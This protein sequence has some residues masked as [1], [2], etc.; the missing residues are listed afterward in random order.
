METDAFVV[1]NG[2][3]QIDS[4]IIGEINEIKENEEIRE[5]IN[6]L[7]SDDFVIHYSSKDLSIAE[8]SGGS[9]RAKIKGD[10]SLDSKI[11]VLESLG[12]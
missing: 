9:I 4:D 10:G 5:L 3:L 8:E 11:K 2:D 1:L 6:T 7:P 12:A